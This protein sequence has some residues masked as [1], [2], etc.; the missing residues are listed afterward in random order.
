MSD[1]AYVNVAGLDLGEADNSYLMPS[2]TYQES[3]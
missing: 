2:K 1:L 3:L